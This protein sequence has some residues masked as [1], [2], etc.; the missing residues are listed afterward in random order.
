MLQLSEPLLWP[1]GAGIR[2]RSYTAP[3]PPDLHD[4]VGA[5]ILDLGWCGLAGLNFIEAP[6]RE[7]LLTD[8]NGRLLASIALSIA[9]GVNLPA[10]WTAQATGRPLTG[11]AEAFARVVAGCRPICSARCDTRSA[12]N[13]PPGTGAT[14]GRRSSW[15]AAVSA[16]R[17]TMYSAC[18]GRV[19]LPHPDRRPADRRKWK[20][21]A[22]WVS[23]G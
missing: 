15:V 22:G 4:K 19:R 21:S 8:F 16:K 10:Y 7:P 6:G 1:P 20:T 9:A 13:T 11:L 12:R 5:L 2:T 14:S 3:V 23:C 17:Y 18:A